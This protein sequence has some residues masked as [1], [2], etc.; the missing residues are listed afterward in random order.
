M[1]WTRGTREKF[2][3]RDAAHTDISRAYVQSLSKE[4]KYVK[5]PLGMWTGGSPEY[6]RLMVSLYGTRGPAA[7]LEDACAQV[8]DQ[9]EGEVA[10][11]CSLQSREGGIRVVVHGDD[12]LSG[13]PRYQLE[14][15]KSITNKHFESKHIMMRASSDLGK[16]LVMLNRKI[17][18]QE[19]GIAYNP[20]YW[21][22]DGVLQVFVRPRSLRLAKTEA[23]G[24]ISG[25]R[26]SRRTQLSDTRRSWDAY[27]STSRVCGL[28]V[29]EG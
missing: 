8:L 14:W 12:P 24:Q 9:F 28:T 26:R 5:L 29:E 15:M 25:R 16:S 17:V 18:W 1:V 27:D 6:G 10:C 21:A 20:D 23:K 22:V 7:I 4:E 11:P 2:R 13:G 19:D 3:Y